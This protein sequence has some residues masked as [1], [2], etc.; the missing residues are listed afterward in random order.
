MEL[1]TGGEIEKK[2]LEDNPELVDETD[3]AIQFEKLLKA[4]VH[5]HA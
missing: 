3:T 4:L 1:L 2:S 5:C